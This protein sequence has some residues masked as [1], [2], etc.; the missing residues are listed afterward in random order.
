VEPAGFT[1]VSALGI[2]EQR[3]NVIADFVDP[4]GRLGDRFRVESRIVLWRAANVLT[5]PGGALF[6]SGDGWAVYRV[7]GD[8][9]KKRPV[10][11]GHRGAEAAEV[12]SGLTAGD[13]V[14]L[15]PGDRV[16]EGARVVKR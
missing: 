10:R 14:I 7:E 4:P 3:V 2:E 5:V 6:R 13:R 8:R 16:A 11:L 15:H 12:L 9:A 1:K